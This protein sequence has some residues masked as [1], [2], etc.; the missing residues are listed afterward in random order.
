[1]F[2]LSQAFPFKTERLF[3]H[4]AQSLGVQALDEEPVSFRWIDLGK[5]GLCVKKNILFTFS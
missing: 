4:P 3:G 2:L 1:L 5:S